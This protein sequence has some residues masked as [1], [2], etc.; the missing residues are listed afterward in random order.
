MVDWALRPRS[1]VA[2][3]HLIFIAAAASPHTLRG[4]SNQQRRRVDNSRLI[5]TTQAE[6]SSPSGEIQLRRADK[7]G[8]LKHYHLRGRRGSAS[9]P[10]LMASHRQVPVNLLMERFAHAAFAPLA[11]DQPRGASGHT[12]GGGNSVNHRPIAAFA[13]AVCS[14]MRLSLV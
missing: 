12:S 2:N 7:I 14:C 4:A 8:A 10:Q 3:P 1:I 5:P 13:L 6:K 11:I 9:Q